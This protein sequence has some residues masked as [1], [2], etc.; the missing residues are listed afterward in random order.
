[1]QITGSTP[2][3]SLSFDISEFLRPNRRYFRPI[4]MKMIIRNKSLRS[5]AGLA[6]HDF[7]SELGGI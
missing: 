2:Q 7:L 6:A 1:M 4:P 3:S 5:F